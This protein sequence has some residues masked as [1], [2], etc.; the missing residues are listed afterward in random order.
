[1]SRPLV[2]ISGRTLPL[3]RLTGV[4]EILRTADAEL[5]LGDYARCVAAAGGL[6]VQLSA[7]SDPEVV[8][9]LDALVLSGGGD[10]DPTRYGAVPTPAVQDVDPDR[11]ARELAWY[12]AARRLRLPVLGICRGQQLINV[13]HGG[14]LH[15]DL[16]AD[17]EPHASFRHPRDARVVSVA[18][19]PGSRLA[20][21]YGALIRVNCLH[22]QAVD[23]VGTGL[24]V[25]ARATDGVVE[26]LEEPGA[27]V[28]AVQ[29]HPEMFP[30][31]EPCFHWLIEAARRHRG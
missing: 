23:R 17:Q 12:A 21:W 31:L 28:V 3:A 4:P 26:G 8:A 22:H 7:H 10:V 18:T 2:G 16:P 13:A 11:D 1:M 5:H 30:A 24:Q 27:D 29:W 19:V 14:T 15:L 20:A 25:T 6:P 9:R